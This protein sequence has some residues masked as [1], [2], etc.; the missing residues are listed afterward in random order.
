MVLVK[1]EL[2]I[3]NRISAAISNSV[4]AMN[5]AA[6]RQSRPSTRWTPVSED[7]VAGAGRAGAGRLSQ[8]GHCCCR[9]CCSKI[10]TIRSWVVATAVAPA[11]CPG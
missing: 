2:T 10:W 8:D 6:S 11:G 4:G 1:I 5:T 7:D 9:P 3:G